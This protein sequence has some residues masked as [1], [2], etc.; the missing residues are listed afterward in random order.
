MSSI[1]IIVNVLWLVS[2]ITTIYAT[3]K[4]GKASVYNDKYRKISLVAH[5][6]MWIFVFLNFIV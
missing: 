3:L 1:K 5:V 6:F 4:D 2:V